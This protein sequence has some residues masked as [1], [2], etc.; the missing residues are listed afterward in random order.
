MITKAAT[1]I[2]PGTDFK[3]VP[4]LFNVVPFFFGCMFVVRFLFILP[5]TA[6]RC[7]MRASA[8]GFSF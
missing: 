2:H 7:A 3:A 5:G 4:M 6:H 1:V 8:S